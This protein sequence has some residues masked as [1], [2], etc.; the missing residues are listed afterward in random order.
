[1]AYPNVA[2]K[3]FSFLGFAAASPT[4]PLPGTSM[5]TEF[6]E[7]RRAISEVVAYLESS[8]L[9]ATGDLKS[10]TVNLEQLDATLVLAIFGDAAPDLSA[11]ETEIG[12]ARDDANT[13]KTAAET[14]ET[15]A[16]T[17]ETNAETAETNAAASA[18]AAV[19][20]A[21]AAVINANLQAT[22]TTGSANAYLVTTPGA[23]T[24]LI[25]GHGIV[26]VANHSN[27]GAA[28]ID[29]DGT[30]A[31]AMKKVVAGTVTALAKGDIYANGHYLMAYDS[32]ASAWIMVSQD[33]ALFAGPVL[34]P[35]EVLTS[36]S[37][38]VALSMTGKNKKTLTLDETTTITVADEVADQVVELWITQGST[39]GTAAWSG[40]DKWLGGSA[41]TLSTTTGEIDIIILASASD[42]TTI[43]GEHLGVAS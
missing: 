43:I 20:S 13:A 22:D 23:L 1:M 6:G 28:T 37:N 26:V 9:D 35:A 3:L 27:T 8:H 41:P 4:S 14:A 12:V 29:V 16:E 40:V 7:V 10:L 2:A 17:A 34:T 5:D 33:L 32:S 21:A 30:G 25:D 11:Y 31:V 15:N 19:I 18:A 36:S 42:G 24:S 38:A 39:G